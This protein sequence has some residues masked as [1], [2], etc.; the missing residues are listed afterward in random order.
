MES[1]RRDLLNDMAE[2]GCGEMIWLSRNITKIRSIPVL[3]SHPKQ[4]PK[5]GVLFLL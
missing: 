3:V 1:F 5:T 4:V 2:L